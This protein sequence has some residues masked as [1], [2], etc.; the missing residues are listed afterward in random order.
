ME[1]KKILFYFENTSYG[2]MKFYKLAV[3]LNNQKYKN[4]ITPIILTSNETIAKSALNDDIETKFFKPFYNNFKNIPYINISPFFAFCRDLILFKLYKKELGHIVSNIKPDW[5]I[6]PSDTSYNE[7][8]ILANMGI[9]S[10]IVQ[11]TMDSTCV[12]ELVNYMRLLTLGRRFSFTE[13]VAD[14]L[15]RRFPAYN[16]RFAALKG[17][18]NGSP[19]KHLVLKLHK[20]LPHCERKGCGKSTYLALNGEA[21]KEIFAEYGV[22]KSKLIV[23]GNP[24]DDQMAVL[25]SQKHKIKQ[26]VKDYFKTDDKGLVT[27]FL[28]PMDN[29]PHYGKYDYI[30]GIKM[31]LR[32]LGRYQS[33]ISVTVKCHPKT[34]KRKYRFFEKEFGCKV[35]GEETGISNEELIL[36]S[37]FVITMS[38][39]VGFHAFAAGVPLI[40][41]NFGMLI[42]DHLKHTGGSIHC[43]SV[44]EIEYAIKELMKENSPLRQGAMEKD[45]KAAQKYMMPDGK[46]VDRIFDLIRE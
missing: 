29:F 6:L 4:H 3:A 40:S 30:T 9:K 33:K 24:E 46:C 23:T 20:I 25:L 44:E 45:K 32:I 2:S 8:I 12:P 18:Y 13:R 10:L 42:P 38:S 21:F 43:T 27:F 1:S 22:D 26:Q 15:L 37:K 16:C 34:D 5:I 14:N 28:Q 19:L 7:Y 39:T 41:F 11:F 36:S 31:I 35:I 17:P